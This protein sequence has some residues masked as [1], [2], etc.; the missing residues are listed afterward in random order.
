MLDITGVYN[1]LNIRVKLSRLGL[2]PGLSGITDQTLITV[3]GLRHGNS[4][5]DQ[6]LVV[7]RIG[8]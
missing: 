8:W 4:L 7:S 1:L 5:K 2:N 6:G 3:L